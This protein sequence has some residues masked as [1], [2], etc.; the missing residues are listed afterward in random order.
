MDR[1]PALKTLLETIPGIEKAWLQAPRDDKLAFPCIIVQYDDENVVFA[2][3]RPYRRVSRWQ[4]TVIVP[5]IPS[6]IP[7]HVAD[8]PM[9]RFDR[10]F[11]EDK[12]HHF[13]Y[14]LYF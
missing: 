2:D 4:L 7:G 8:L 1:W 5:R 9:C 12:L 14:N 13:I 10:Y 11:V 6:P 3:N